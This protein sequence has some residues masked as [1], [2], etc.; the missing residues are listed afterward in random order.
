MSDDAV[1]PGLRRRDF[2][3]AGAGAGLALAGPGPLNY[4]AIARAKTLPVAT[5][6]KFAHG[7]SSGFPSPK[8]ITL[9]TRVSELQHSSRLTLEV[10][11]DN[12]FRHVVKRQ[13]VIA[14][15]THDFTVHARISGLKPAHEYV[16]RFHTKDKN[17]CVGTYGT[18]PPADSNQKLRIG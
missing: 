9:W 1:R 2:V 4:V 8:G 11:T 10:A 6:G 12:H 15:T 5:G 18:L 13:E 14:D 16:L 17:S 3:L 7:V